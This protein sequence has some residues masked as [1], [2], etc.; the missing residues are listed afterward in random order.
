MAW[1]GWTATV[2]NWRWISL[3]DSGIRSADLGGGRVVGTDR[4][5]EGMGEHREGDSAGL[6]G[7]AADLV[8]IESRQPFPVWKVSSTR[9][10]E[11][12]TLTRGGQWRR[13][14]GMTA[15]VGEFAS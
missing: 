4:R 10:L 7:V 1:R 15:V 5:K 13:P 12:A 2:M 3:Q 9:H 14:G 11:P 6:G 8:V